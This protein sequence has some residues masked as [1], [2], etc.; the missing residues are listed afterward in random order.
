MKRLKRTAAILLLALLAVRGLWAW[1]WSRDMIVQPALQPLLRLFL[2]APNSIALGR[3]PAMARDVAAQKLRNPLAR[4]PERLERGK[5]L[6]VTYCAVCHDLLGKGHGPVAQGA[7]QPSDLTSA[8]VQAR[9]DGYL[10]VTIRN[11]GPTM[12]RYEEAL[13]VEERWLVVLHVRTLATTRS[14]LAQK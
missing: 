13:T 3:E 11:G 10:Y 2:P 9:S 6:Y 12:P 1:P 7:L 4:S 14:G 5:K 8:A